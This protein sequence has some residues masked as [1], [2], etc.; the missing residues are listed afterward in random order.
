[1]QGFYWDKGPARQSAIQLDA[2]NG[3]VGVSLWVGHA[4][5]TIRSAVP[6]YLELRRSK[7]SGFHARGRFQSVPHPEAGG[8]RKTVRLMC[9]KGNPAKIQSAHVV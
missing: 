7:I 3:S 4:L 6:A 9:S 2:P 5:K 1:M 8:S